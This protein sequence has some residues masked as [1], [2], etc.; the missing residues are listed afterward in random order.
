MTCF[1]Y[2]EN[3]V[4]YLQEEQQL[5]E[6][7]IITQVPLEIFSKTFELYTAKNELGILGY[8]SVSLDCLC[9][10]ISKSLDFMLL[11]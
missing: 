10:D 5:F 9:W 11:Y 4:T 2:W 1:K 8:F 7:T 6:K 3:V